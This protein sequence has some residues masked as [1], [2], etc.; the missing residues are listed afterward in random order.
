MRIDKDAK[1]IMLDPDCLKCAIS[2]L[3]TNAVQAMPGSG[4]ISVHVY[5]DK[6]TNDVVINV[7]DRGVSIPDDVKGKLF[8][9]M[10]TAKSKGQGFGLAVVK[11]IAEASGGIVTFES[12]KGKRHSLHSTIALKE[13]NRTQKSNH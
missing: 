10:F 5:N 4:K 2:N 6:Q 9:P 13:E 12:Q 11:R 1:S 3:V 8:T 7:K